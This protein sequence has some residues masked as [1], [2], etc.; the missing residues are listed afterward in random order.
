M[1]ESRNGNR[2]IRAA[3]SESRRLLLACGHLLKPILA[4][5]G[6]ALREE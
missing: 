2:G 6:R 1:A 5:F 4:S 3:L